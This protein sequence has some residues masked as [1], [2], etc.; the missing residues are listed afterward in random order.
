MFHFLVYLCLLSQHLLQLAHVK[1]ILLDLGL[2]GREL[3]E[4][5]VDPGRCLVGLL[6]QGTKEAQLGLDLWAN[7][8]RLF[9]LRR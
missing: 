3:V 2:A 6:G 7:V 4:E 5:V 1:V 9:F 8:N